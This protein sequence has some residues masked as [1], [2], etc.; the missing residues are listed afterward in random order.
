M[1]NYFYTTSYNEKSILK[2][3]STCNCSFLEN[4]LLQV[5]C[6]VEASHNLVKCFQIETI[7][8]KQ[9]I[10]DGGPE[11]Y[12]C[13][14]GLNVTVQMKYIFP[15]LITCLSTR[16]IVSNLLTETLIERNM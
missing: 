11:Q 14:N 5:L 15:V 6:L 7:V 9:V 13:V 1:C 10:N 8:D 12:H 4:V 2:L 16:I 3:Y